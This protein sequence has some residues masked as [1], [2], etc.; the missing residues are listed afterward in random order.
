MIKRILL[1]LIG[2]Q[3]I[4][5][6]SEL[7]FHFDKIDFISNKVKLYDM[8][9]SEGS[10]E[11]SVVS[12]E[13]INLK[14]DHFKDEFV[15]QNVLVFQPPLENYTQEKFKKIYLH[16]ENMIIPSLSKGEQYAITG[17]MLLHHC[18]QIFY[19]SFDAFKREQIIYFWSIKE[20]F[21][22][23]KPFEIPNDIFMVLMKACHDLSFHVN[24]IHIHKQQMIYT[25]LKK[26]EN[27][28]RKYDEKSFLDQMLA[29][30]SQSMNMPYQKRDI[31]I[32]IEWDEKQ[33]GK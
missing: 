29:P 10:D 9:Y 14:L 6:G 18:K 4:V 12:I 22:S 25:L 15:R 26:L 27:C 13:S 17:V 11:T 24:N 5:Y 21:L 28:I 30:L 2:L 31:Y 20:L 32:K 1:G 3:T 7:T 23:L 16:L 33:A 8:I 19:S